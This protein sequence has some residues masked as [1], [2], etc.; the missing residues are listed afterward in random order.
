MAEDRQRAGAGA[1]TLL[2]A[3]GENPFEQ[4]VI[5]IHGATVLDPWKRRVLAT[6]RPF[7]SDDSAGRLDYTRKNEHPIAKRQGPRRQTRPA[8]PRQPPA[9]NIQNGLTRVANAS[10]A[11]TPVISAAAQLRSEVTAR[12]RPEAPISPIDSGTSAA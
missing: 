3:V 4:I 9:K 6:G 7:D 5:L 10:H 11:E 12:I 2:R 1:V 8:K